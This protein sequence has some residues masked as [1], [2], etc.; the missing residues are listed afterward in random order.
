M[1]YTEEAMHLIGCQ[2][3][4]RDS[5]KTTL[6]VRQ[7]VSLYNRTPVEALELWEMCGC[8]IIPKTHP[9]HM[10]WCLLYLKL[11]IPL[12]SMSIMLNVSIPT[13]HKWIWI[14]IETIAS[15]HHD[16]IHWTRRFRNAPKDVWCFISVDGTDFQI[17]EPTPWNKQWKGAKNPGA[18]IKY[19]VAISIYSGDIVWI[20]GPH[21]GSKNDKKVFREHLK[22]MLDD[23]EMVEAD[24]GYGLPGSGGA[25]DDIVRSK[26]DFHSR[27]EQREKSCLRARHETVNHR[28][29]TWGALKQQFRNN[30]KLHQYVF[31]A[32]AVMTQMS[33]DNGNVLFGVEPKTLKKQDR[34]HI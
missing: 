12:D 23:G 20:H 16:V 6:P 3:A 22:N 1:K 14:W 31:Y 10:F 17:P 24:A 15:R 19:E 11:Y 27:E 34:Y 28:F 26:L 13:L 32:C 8:T 29:K 7:F 9:K 30:K 2:V 5:A 18:S 25:G 4:S 33:I 21:E